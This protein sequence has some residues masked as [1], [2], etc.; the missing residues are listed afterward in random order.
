MLK[1]LPMGKQK[2][3]IDYDALYNNAFVRALKS[4]DVNRAIF[5]GVKLFGFRDTEKGDA[6][7]T[8]ALMGYIKEL[9]SRLTPRELMQLFPVRKI[10]DGSRCQSKDYFSTMEAL[11][12]HG[13]DNPLSEAVSEILWDYVNH[14]I[15]DFQLNLYSI[16]GKLHKQQTGRD[17]LSDFLENQGQHLTTY[18]EMINPDTREKFMRNNDT[19]ELV[20]IKKRIPRY[21]KLM[22]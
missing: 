6:D 12:Q 9:I 11:G 15:D 18:T 21:L 10:Y 20:P 19:G 1:L 5:Y 17:M 13:L 7:N 16:V 4:Q 2:P 8:F 14:D 3:Q 22:Q